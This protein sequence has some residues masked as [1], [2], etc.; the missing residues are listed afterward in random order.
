MARVSNWNIQKYD[1]EFIEASMDRLRKAA[2]VIADE[3]RRRVNVNTGVL[4]D[5]IRVVEKYER[6]GTEIAALG[7]DR[8]IRVYAGNKEINYAWA[9]EYA[10]S[11][12]GNG[13]LRKSL[14]A[15]KG[16]IREILENG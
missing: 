1:G 12:G 13:F 6:Y 4:K 15:S 3:A 10:L 5:T 16:R 8:N 7:K 9:Q 11:H 2:E 14:N